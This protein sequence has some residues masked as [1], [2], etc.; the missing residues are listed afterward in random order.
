MAH[1]DE[2][3]IVKEIFQYETEKKNT[4]NSLEIAQNEKFEP[5]PPPP[6]R[7]LAPAPEYP[8][9]TTTTKFNYIL[10]FLPSIICWVIGTKI[11]FLFFLSLIGTFW[12]PYY[13]F[14]I[15][16]KNKKA[17]FESIK[18]SIE[19][20]AQCEELDKQRAEQQVKL[21]ILHNQHLKEYENTILTS[22]NKELHK[23]QAEQNKQINTLESKL[24]NINTHLKKLYDNS[25][26]IPHHYRTID[27]LKYIKDTISTSNF[28]V[29]SAIEMY[30]RNE[31]RKIDEARL[32]E[33]KIANQYAA[34]Q[35]QL[36]QE[37]NALTEEQN[38]IAE[39][40]R[41]DA[42]IATAVS[43]IQRHNTNKYLKNR[44]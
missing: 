39:K 14:F 41:R 38:F 44:K 6:N 2:V 17:E 37:Q 21:D 18:N 27:A 31:Q 26:L 13:Y 36:L 8:P 30:D 43:T 15:F 1:E 4:T 33:Q 3:K 19:Y 40:T 11:L 12:I 42:N 28:D 16:K 7:T 22:Y 34:D 35:N 25:Q 10:C 23:W 5:C 24:S 20:R 29:K 32:R 9:I